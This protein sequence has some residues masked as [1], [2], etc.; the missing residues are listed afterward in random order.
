MPDPS[1]ALQQYL[2]SKHMTQS[3]AARA[4][5][6]SRVFVGFLLKRQ[7]TPGLALSIAIERFTEDAD[8][9]PIRPEDWI[10]DAPELAATGTEG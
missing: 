4:L 3:E 9:G 10:A 8:G 1:A 2:A 5:G 6:C 7:R